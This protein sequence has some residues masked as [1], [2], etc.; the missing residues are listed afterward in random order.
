MLIWYAA[1]THVQENTALVSI[2]FTRLLKMYLKVEI[3]LK[4]DNAIGI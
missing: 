4:N 1:E 3:V 2:I